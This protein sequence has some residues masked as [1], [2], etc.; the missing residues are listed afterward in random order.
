MILEDF[1]MLGR[2]APEESKKHGLVVCSAGYSKEL[3]QFIRIY[4]ISMFDSIPRWSICRVKVRRNPGDSRDESWRIDDEYPIEIIGKADKNVEYDWLESVAADSIAEMN[5]K[6]KS[7]AIIKPEGMQFRFDGLRH[8]AERQLQLIEGGKPEELRPRVKF[9]DAAGA[10]DLQIRDWGC[11]MFLEKYPERDYQLW[12]AL[13]LTK[14][15]YEHLFFVG[16]M[17]NHRNN[18]LVISVVSRKRETQIGLF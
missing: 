14:D 3:R 1:V 6:R 5:E 10:H 12:D 17:A 15:N 8:G 18:W 9:R 4:P 7:L 2:T 16:N 11:R 13:N